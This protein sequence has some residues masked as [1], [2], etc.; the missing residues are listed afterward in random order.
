MFLFGLQYPSVSAST[1]M[2]ILVLILV[3]KAMTTPGR[4]E[5]NEEAQQQLKRLLY[6]GPT[7]FRREV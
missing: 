3:C 7:T 5:E 4:E 1:Q 6:L 2:E